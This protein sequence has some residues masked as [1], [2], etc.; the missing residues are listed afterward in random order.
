MAP[1]DSYS[2]PVRS[3]SLGY[4]LALVSVA[5]ALMP[6]LL[7]QY[8]KFK[9][10]EFPLFLFAVAF[11]A[12]HWGS[13]P[14]A[15]SILLSSLCFDYFFTEPLYSLSFTLAYVPELIIFVSFAALIAWFSSIRRRVERQLR[16]AR[17]QLQTEVEERTQQASLLDLT[18]DSIFVR[19][20]DNVI[21][22]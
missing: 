12:W 9:D 13:G 14:A 20:M 17:D 3:T 4:G 11:S 2:T 22:I 1:S 21:E 5:V 15:L 6:A 8:F 7:L 18:H 10:V 16:Q 19:D